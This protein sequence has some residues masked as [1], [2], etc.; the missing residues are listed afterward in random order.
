MVAPADGSD[1]GGSLRNP[2]SFCNVFGLRPT[3]GRVPNLPARD[4]WFDLSVLGPLGRCAADAALLLSTI[5][6]PDIADPYAAIS[7]CPDFAVRL[8]RDFTGAGGLGWTAG[9]AL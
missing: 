3:P 2:A 1:M 8:G 7:D 6:G 4:G 9:V 5:A